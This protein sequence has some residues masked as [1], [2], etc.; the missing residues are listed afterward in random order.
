VLGKMPEDEPSNDRGNAFEA[1]EA[2]NAFTDKVVLLHGEMVTKYVR[3]LEKD[4][5][6]AQMNQLIS[7]SIFDLLDKPG[8]RIIKSSSTIAMKFQDNLE[9]IKAYIE[10]NSWFVA[11]DD[12]RMFV[13]QTN[14]ALLDIINNNRN[15][16]KIVSPRKFEELTAYIYQESGYETELTKATRDG[17]IDIKVKT[18]PALRGT[19]FLTVVQAKHRLSGTIHSYEIQQLEGARVGADAHRAALVST[20]EYSKDSIKYAKGQKI[21][22]LSFFE[23]SDDYQRLSRI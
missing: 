15:E 22:L 4:D 12:T 20:A 7:D 10:G 18:L 23:L 2:I 19:P 21:D 5:A 16:I 17:G 3:N 13:G 6:Y 9:R 1:L 14:R 11:F 8:I